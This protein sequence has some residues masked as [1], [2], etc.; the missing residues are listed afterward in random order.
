MGIL[1][2][3]KGII[4]LPCALLIVG[5]PFVAIGHYRCM[6]ED[7]F[8]CFAPYLQNN[9]G[10]PTTI[11]SLSSYYNVILQLLIITKKPIQWNIG[12]IF[13]VLALIITLVEVKDTFQNS[14]STSKS[15]KDEHDIQ[16]ELMSTHYSH[17]EILDQIKKITNQIVQSRYQRKNNDNSDGK[18]QEQEK[19]QEKCCFKIKLK[20]DYKTI[21]CCLNAFALKIDLIKKK[22]KPKHKHLSKRDTDI[23]T[24]YPN[25]NVNTKKQ[26]QLLTGVMETSHEACFNVLRTI[27]NDID[28]EVLCSVLSLLAITAKHTSIRERYVKEKDFYDVS[29]PIQAME[30]SLDRTKKYNPSQKKVDKDDNDV[31][32]YDGDDYGDEI[33]HLA[34]EVQRKGC[35]YLGALSDGDDTKLASRIVQEGGLSIILESMSWFQYHSHVVNWALWALFN[36][37]YVHKKIKLELLRLGGIN[38]ICTV[39]KNILDKNQNGA[40][41]DEIDD[42]GSILEVARHGVA[43]MFDLLRYDETS[44]QSNNNMDQE[45]PFFMQVRRIALNAGLHNVLTLVMEKFPNDMQIMMMGQQILISTGFTGDVPSYEGV[46]VPKSTR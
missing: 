2:T 4:T 31:S 37:C 5:I 24:N 17:E 3:S 36:L 33:E 29:I 13:I 32:D 11:T 39:M 1:I 19:E 9:D 35:I 10:M 22:K 14:K 26:E 45:T 18:K 43:I 7:K 12:I 34:A 41:D 28:D 6:N 38:N 16:T 23:P 30:S 46:L 21:I 25:N 15:V 20:R 8:S 27:Q 44:E 40:D 42:E